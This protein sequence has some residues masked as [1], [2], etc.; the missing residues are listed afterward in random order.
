[1]SENS[2]LETAEELAQSDIEQG[3]R[4]LVRVVGPGQQAEAIFLE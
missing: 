3:D 1:M 2:K 4:V